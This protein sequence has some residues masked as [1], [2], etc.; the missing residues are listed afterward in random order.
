MKDKNIADFH[1]RKYASGTVAVKVTG[2]VKTNIA[3]IAVGIK[4]LAADNKAGAG[5][6]CDL[7]R[8][9]LTK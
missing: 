9:L 1:V 8:S 7:L 3:L 4:Q 5:E 6:I 2:D